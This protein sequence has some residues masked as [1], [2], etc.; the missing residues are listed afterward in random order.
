MEEK[1]A[2]SHVSTQQ[3]DQMRQQSAQTEDRSTQG[4]AVIRNN[5]PRPRSFSLVKAQADSPLPSVFPGEAPEAPPLPE[6]ETRETEE[7]ERQQ[8]MPQTPAEPAMRPL[9]NE[10]IWLFEYALDMD[11]LRLNRP[12]RLD[13]SAFAYGPAVLKGYRLVFDGLETRTGQVVA[14]LDAT[15]EQ[16]ESEIWGILYRVPRRF[17]QSQGNTVPLLDRVHNSETFIAHKIQV[18]DSYR[19]REIACITYIASAY[20]RQQIEQLPPASRTPEQTYLTRLL[21]IGRR[22]KLPTSYIQS[23]EK[24]LYSPLAGHVPMLEQ[25]TE[26]IPV[27]RASQAKPA[28]E[29]RRQ[30]PRSLPGEPSPTEHEHKPRQRDGWLIAFS[31][32]VSLLLVCTLM[33]IIF[34]GLSLKANDFSHLLDAP[35]PWSIFLYSLLGGCISCVISLGRPLR[36]AHPPLFVVLTWFARPFLGAFL[37][38]LAYLILNTGFFLLST[39]P[40]QHFSLC[41]TASTLAALCEGRLL[42]A[43]RITYGKAYSDTDEKQKPLPGVLQHN[44]NISEQRLL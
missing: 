7:S 4:V 21:Q 3:P 40:V 27:F 13:G 10:F 8:Q 1:Y 19:Q 36:P 18:Q 12:E 2:V 32:Y 42:V 15:P 35:L 14:S 34:Q 5:T 11:P 33:L 26:P 30:I 25:H 44:L 24:L 28:L 16:P 6:E 41:A 20:S 38:A 22:Q 43:E 9:L 17:T 39:Q 37:G 31:I 29:S 23:L